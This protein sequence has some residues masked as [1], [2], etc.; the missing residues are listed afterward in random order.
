MKAGGV[1]EH[2]DWREGAAGKSKGKGEKRL[3]RAE[4]PLALQGADSEDEGME[5][6]EA[7]GDTRSQRDLEAPGGQAEWGGGEVYIGAMAKPGRQR[8]G[9]GAGERGR[10]RLGKKERGLLKTSQCITQN[11]RVYSFI[12]GIAGTENPAQKCH[13]LSCLIT[14]CLLTPSLQGACLNLPL[15]PQGTPETE[16]IPGSF[17]GLLVLP[18]GLEGE[19]L[20]GAPK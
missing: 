16:N 6:P 17:S 11:V 12:L 15:G 3:W 13:R 4:E 5:R 7:C 8:R 14:C 18:W 20:P 9:W 10:S 19:G 1:A 2:W